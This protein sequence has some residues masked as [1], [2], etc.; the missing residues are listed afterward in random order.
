MKRIGLLL[1]MLLV[2]AGCGGKNRDLERAMALRSRLLGASECS[3]R[4][5]I[6]ADY[7]DRVH[8]FT[9]ENQS[10]QNGNVSFTV[11]EPESIAGITGVIRDSGGELIFDDTALAFPMLADDQL[12]PVSAPW[13][14]L[15]TLRSGYLTSA[16]KDGD[17]MRITIDDRY[18]DDALTMDI[19]VD[20]EDRPVYAEILWKG[21]NIL[22]ITVEN[23]QIV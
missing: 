15:K 17:L 18:E 13:L 12:A 20:R 4:T 6:T 19:W 14:L 2:L 16:G 7:G 8:T 23:F 1:C 21:E 3:F 22:T 5:G 10:D 9:M 11:S